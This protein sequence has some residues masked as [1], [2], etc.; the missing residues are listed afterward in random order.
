MPTPNASCK[1]DHAT[2]AETKAG[3]TDTWSSTEM[4]PWR[5]ASH[6]PHPPFVADRE[7]G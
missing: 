5:G 3:A 2:D 6:A 4:T 1:W 7:R